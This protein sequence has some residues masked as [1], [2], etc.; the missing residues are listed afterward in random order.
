MT[1][2]PLTPSPDSP[3]PRTD[4]VAKM[5]GRLAFQLKDG[6]LNLLDFADVAQVELDKLGA[7][8]REN[9]ALVKERE[10]LDDKVSDLADERDKYATTIL[11][12]RATL[13]ERDREIETLK[14]HLV[15]YRQAEELGVDNRDETIV[16]LRAQLA[17]TQ[18]KLKEAD[19]QLLALQAHVETLRSALEE[20]KRQQGAYDYCW[21]VRNIIDPALSSQPEL[22]LIEEVRE[23]LKLGREYAFRC[24]GDSWTGPFDQLLTRL[25][26]RK[27]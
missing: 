8:E 12:L 7:I 11:S 24:M 21:Y 22:P 4:A 15:S 13:A 18:E 17:E 10:A 3:T 25:N 2:D 27:D 23:A 20:L 19:A 26:P 14:S 6:V 9:A 1:P 5:I 16:T